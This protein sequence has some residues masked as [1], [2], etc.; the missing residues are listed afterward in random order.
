[1]P[2][3]YS[4]RMCRTDVQGVGTAEALH[5]MT[6]DHLTH[7]LNL[8][9]DTCFLPKRN[10]LLLNLHHLIESECRLAERNEQWWG[11]SR[12]RHLLLPVAGKTER[13][14]IPYKPQSTV[15]PSLRIKQDTQRKN[16]IL[17]L[18]HLPSRSKTSQS[19]KVF[20]NVH[21][22]KIWNIGKCCLRLTNVHFPSI[23][24]MPIRGEL[25]QTSMSKS[26]SLK[27][28]RSF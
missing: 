2:L 26:E 16:I 4:E 23:H 1:M 6:T 25:P 27:C 18:S 12:R 5:E 21:E 17:H 28:C 3:E 14:S 13:F 11:P 8:E 15:M 10:P 9:S 24:I 20:E 22:Q 7:S 19:I